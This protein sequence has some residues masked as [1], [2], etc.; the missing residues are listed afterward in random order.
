MHVHFHSENHINFFKINISLSG[1][2]LILKTN[3]LKH[4]SVATNFEPHTKLNLIINNLSTTLCTDDTGL[5]ETQ[6]YIQQTL[7]ITH[8]Q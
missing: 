6:F 2:E 3:V 5:V 8:T 4:N 7:I 1:V